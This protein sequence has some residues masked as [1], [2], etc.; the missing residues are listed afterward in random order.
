MSSLSTADKQY[1]D[2]ALRLGAGGC[3]VHFTDEQ[4]TPTQPATVSIDNN[5]ISIEI[6][7][8]IKDYL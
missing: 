3:I 2:N 5:L 1:I 4:P 7:P 6:R 8:E